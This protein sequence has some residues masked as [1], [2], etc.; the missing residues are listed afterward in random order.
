METSGNYIIQNEDYLT[1]FTIT[2]AERRHTGIYKINAKNDSGTD[3]ADLEI[4][5]LGEYHMLYYTLTVIIYI[6]YGI[7]VNFVSHWLRIK[8]I[9]VC[10][11]EAVY[12][13]KSTYP[14]ILLRG[15]KYSV[16]YPLP[17]HVL[18]L[19]TWF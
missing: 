7:T 2:E 3:E 13:F 14:I 4:V 10:F 11:N 8:E 19:N 18:Q 17:V 6:I 16:V 12:A 9:L 1:K 15:H 5:V